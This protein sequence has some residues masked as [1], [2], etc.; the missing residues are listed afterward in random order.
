[1]RVTA[2]FFEAASASDAFVV[3][4][5]LIAQLADGLL[6]TMRQLLGVR[7]RLSTNPELASEIDP[8]D[9]AE[10]AD[11]TFAVADDDDDDKLDDG[12]PGGDD[13][14]GAAFAAADGHDEEEGF[15]GLVA[16][17]AGLL[18]SLAELRPAAYLA[19][20]GAPLL[21]LLP[22]FAAASRG[23]GGAAAPPLLFDLGTAAALLRAVVTHAPPAESAA[24][25]R[26]LA[27]A[28]PP[29][30]AAPPPPPSPLHWRARAPLSSYTYTYTYTYCG[31]TCTIGVLYDAYHGC[32]TL[33]RRAELSLLGL[34]R[35][36]CATLTACAGPANSPA[37][38][39]AHATV[40]GCLAAAVPRALRLV[41]TAPGGPAG[42]AASAL[43]LSLCGARWPAEARP[44]FAPLREHTAAAAALVPPARRPEL[45]A[46]ASL[47]L[48]LPPAG[49]MA[50]ARASASKV[51]ACSPQPEACE[52][53]AALVS[54]QH[55]RRSVQYVSTVRRSVSR[56]VRG[57]SCGGGLAGLEPHPLP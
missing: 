55:T 46:A 42:R 16:E 19:A 3:G 20:A 34:T 48:L 45:L 44:A 25:A 23:E 50:A 51:A 28:L 21:E 7:L 38:T 9:A 5:E 8:S 47:A 11:R 1:M 27:E 15:A 37:A 40:A 6:P 30:P 33:T 13:G 41:A 54:Q 52:A 57:L 29:L 56:S 22:A 2:L 24:L 32:T 49:F 14:E 39:A 43:L 18:G 12:G 53:F 36:Q 26:H 10:W 4:H 31:H 17:V 35:L